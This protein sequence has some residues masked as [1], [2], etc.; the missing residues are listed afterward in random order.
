MAP[1]TP[2]KPTILIKVACF[3]NMVWRSVG[4]SINCHIVVAK[5]MS[6]LGNFTSSTLIKKKNNV[7]DFVSILHSCLESVVLFMIIMQ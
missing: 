4:E 5:V 1:T 3:C 6:G 7:K 2:G